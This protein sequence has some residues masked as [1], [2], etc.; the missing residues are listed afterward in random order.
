MKQEQ[1]H[2]TLKKK[3]RKDEKGNKRNLVITIKKVQASCW[4]TT[5]NKPTKTPEYKT[6]NPEAVIFWKA[7]MTSP[8]NFVPVRSQAMAV[9]RKSNGNRRTKVRHPERS[10]LMPGEPGSLRNRNEVI[11]RVAKSLANLR[12]AAPHNAYTPTL[13][14]IYWMRV[15]Q[16]MVDNA[17]KKG[18]TKLTYRNQ[19]KDL[20]FLVLFLFNLSCSVL[21]IFLLFLI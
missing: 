1:F 7:P 9:K 12:E 11:T 17:I 10:D 13:L 3:K 6:E 20:L 14:M 4:A 15:I 19:P 8:P 2:N 21:F 16:S 18:S 5:P